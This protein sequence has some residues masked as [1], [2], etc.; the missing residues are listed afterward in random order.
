[1]H[2]QKCTTMTLKQKYNVR[3]CKQ[4]PL[5]EYSSSHEVISQT[6]DKIL[7]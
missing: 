6:T 5:D 3:P 1:M 2:S 7:S 4:T